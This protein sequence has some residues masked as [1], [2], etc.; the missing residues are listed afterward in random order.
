MTTDKAENAVWSERRRKAARAFRAWRS[1]VCESVVLPIQ[2]S[3]TRVRRALVAGELLRTRL[4]LVTIDSVIAGTM[5]DMDAVTLKAVRT[6]E[7]NCSVFELFVLAAVA[8]AVKPRRV[9]EIGTYDGRSSLAMALNLPPD[10]VQS[11]AGRPIAY[12]EKLAEKVTSGYRWKGHEAANSITQVFANSMEFDFSPYRT[13]QLIFIDGGHSE[14]VVNSDTKK[15]LEIIDRE[16]GAIL[17]HDATRYGVKPALERLAAQ[18]H[19]ICLIEG[20]SVAIL[21][22]QGGKEVQLRY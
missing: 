14:T 21:R 9:V 4:P 22:F 12:D 19:K 10:H 1:L 13:S 20:T 18:G 16:N 7:H 17:W 2:P 5:T 6:H 3:M 8:K 15:C 11:Q